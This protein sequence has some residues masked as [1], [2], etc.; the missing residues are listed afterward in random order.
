MAE[1]PRRWGLALQVLGTAG[2]VAFLAWRIDA[3]AL[4]DRLA[5]AAPGGVLVGVGLVVAVQLAT[6]ERWR[7]ILGGAGD[8]VPAGVTARL[9][10][11]GLFLN[12]VLP[13]FVGGDALRAVRLRRWGVPVGRGLASVV[14]DR[15]AG[16]AA[17]A[18]SALATWPVLH[19]RLGG[20]PLAVAT[21]G[22]G[23]GGLVATLGF[24][25]LGWRAPGPG[26]LGAL[27]APARLAGAT[28]ATPRGRRPL[29]T[30]STLVQ[31]LALLSFLPLARATG[32][33]APA[34]EVVAVLPAT[35]LL[36]LLPL[37]IGGWGVREGVIAGAFSALGHP[38][39]PAVA[40][41]VVFGLAHAVAALPGAVSWW[42]GPAE[43]P[44]AAPGD[45]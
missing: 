28:L 6:A 40:A 38:A 22:V 13:G 12:Q 1:G 31:G 20:H 9:V 41:S 37:S 26:R 36:S 17:L 14:V 23:V 25:A 4:G 19:A 32:V 42:F 44:G 39:E 30:W 43:A 45:E 2:G 35:L 11:E 10:L 33:T 5:G 16:L 18:V 7:A 8:R 27:L 24:L 3:G 34:L 29:I 15:V 21:L